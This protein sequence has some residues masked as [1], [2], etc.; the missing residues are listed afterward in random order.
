[1]QPPEPK[2]ISGEHC[3][4]SFPYIFLLQESHHVPTR[5]LL[6]LHEA[7]LDQLRSSTSCINVDSGL[8]FGSSWFLPPTSSALS[9]K[10]SCYICFALSLTRC[11][12]FTSFLLVYCSCLYHSAL[13]LCIYLNLCTLT[14]YTLISLCYI[15]QSRHNASSTLEKTS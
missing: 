14:P 7:P 12:S 2:S 6:E 13:L 4:G 9:R 11:S 3:P 10:L 15:I 8:Y 1:M 5:S